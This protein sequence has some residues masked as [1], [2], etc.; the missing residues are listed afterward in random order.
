M[1]IR[2]ALALAMFALALAPVA[3]SADAQQ[4]Q[5]ACM[6]DA[7]TVCGQFIPDRERVATCLISNRSRISEACRAALAHFDPRT[8][9]AR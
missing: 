7:L 8:A 1:K 3:V 9:S 2:I 6:N 5:Q 4:N